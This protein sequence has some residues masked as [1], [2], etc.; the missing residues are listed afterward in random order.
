[1]TIKKTPRFI[2]PASCTACGDCAAV[3]PVIRPSEYDMELVGRKA[4]YKPYA[5]A[6]PGGFAIEKLD[7]APCRMACPANLN[8]QGYVQMV[9]MGKFREA[10]EIIM[11]D[12]PFPGTLGRV[13]PHACEKSCRRLEID[14]AISIRELKRVAADNTNLSDIPVPEIQRRDEKVAI[15]G[16]GP[17]GLTA[18]Y[19]L[20]LDGYQVSVY[21][22]MPEAGGMMRY[23]IPEHR[24]PRSVLDSEINNLKR[25]GIEIH[26][27]TV[28][29]KDLSIEELREHGAKA[30]F[31]GA[32]AWKGLKLRIQGEESKG[33][34]DVTSFLREV[35][36][37]NLKNLKGKA[38]II[39][40]GHSAL[41]GARVALRLGAEES[42][43][44]YRR[45]KTEM[46]AEP[47][48]IEEAEKEGIKIH[49]LVGPV[50]IVSQDGKVTGIECIRTRL[51][52]PDTTGRRKPIPI[53]G[54]EFIIEAD[55]IIP[56]IGQEP[57]LAFIGEKSD[58]EVSKW[59]LLVVNAETLQTNVPGIFAGGD[60]VTGPA[61]VIEAVDAG[62]RAAKYIAKYLQGEELPKEWHEEP[63]MGTNW[64]EI[65]DDEPVKHRM[66]APT[67]AVEKRFSG[68][69]EVNLTA[70][71]ET[72]KA[73]AARCL[74]CGGCCEC[75]ECV[76]ACKAHAVTF[77][78]HAQMA[79]T[80]TIDVGAVILAP[81]FKAFEPNDFATYQYGNF[82]NVVT[83]MEYE[84]ILS[85]TGPHQGHLLRPSD[86]KEPR[87]IGWLQCI[88][89]RDINQCDNGY[90]SSVCCMY[91]IKE[92]VIS[93]EHADYDLDTAIF[94]MD[95][96]TYGKDFEKYY[97]RAKEKAVRFV[98]ARLHTLEEDRE[99]KDIIVRYA[100]EK[101]DI[102]VETFD[103]MVL[104]VGM[105][106]RKE[107]T[108]MAKSLGIALDADNFADTGVFTPVETSRK[109]VY[110]CGAFQEPKDIPYSV[111][112]ASAAACGA[113]EL[114]SQARGTMV[115]EMVYPEEIDVSS[116]KPRIGVFVCNCGINI[117]GIV[118]VPAVVEYAGTLPGVV[119]IEDNLFTCSQDTQQKMVET[120]K[121]HKLNRIVV[122]ACTPRTHEPLFQETLKSAGLNK[123]LFEMANIRNQCSWVHSKEKEE[124]TAKAKDLV[125]MA[126]ARAN[127]IQPLPQPSI[128]VDSKAL[129]IGGGI[130]GM[131]AALGLAD[132]GYHT[133]LVEQSNVLGGNALNLFKTWRGD[134]IQQQI[135]QIIEKVSAHP[136]IDVYTE[137]AI[138]EATGFIGNYETTVTRNGNDIKLKHGAIVVAV[139]ADELKPQE[140]LY[141]EDNRVM[142]H[143]ELDE[144]MKKGEVS[145]IKTAVF[146]QC[147]GSREPQR[148][149]CS[150]VCC[151]HSVKS[152]LKLKEI[153]PETNVYILYRDIRTYGQ[154]E[155]LYKEARN[156][157]VIFI[158]YNLDG[159]PRVEKAGSGISV[160]IKDHIL[161]QDIVINPDLLVL[162]SGIIPRDN[163]AL[164]Q[165]FKLSLTEDGF[166]MEAHAKLRPVEFATD[167]IFL[168]G[169]A[170]YPKPIEES[171]AQ[172]KAAASRASVVLS[173]ETLTVEGVVSH[174]NEIMCRGCG[175]CVEACPFNAISLEPRPGGKIVAHVQEAMCKG[176]GS[177][178]VVC[179]TGAAAI[180]HYD[181]QEV[182]TMVEAAFK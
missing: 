11:R 126:V 105:E 131:T 90:C 7:K 16:S 172:A 8:V 141:G 160:T 73:E 94:F 75:Y 31:L 87:K 38:V 54:S 57:D 109:G 56:A 28:I 9:K 181:D 171:I 161:Q 58:L 83:S 113:K 182:L 108:E 140:Y 86:H 178:S 41:D 20:A 34:A 114:L 110:V 67:L 39:G 180:F 177:C 43:I 27:N 55:H 101:G 63:P 124:A 159:K 84:R 151:T 37:G 53:E 78:T 2:D 173:K 165:M 61:T 116:E 22:A 80:L 79:E 170:H 167:G 115:K 10:I 142:T 70:D 5:Q 149:Y 1:M 82:A 64:V 166:F 157:G 162:A 48:E 93:K 106:A 52:E 6:I 4:T 103:M 29:G 59:N 179:P 96:R 125:R 15:I 25:Y 111:M 168:A 17:A 107:V 88:G 18:A 137:A 51:T 169:M 163:N 97:D 71:E 158:R 132:Q 127:L 118:D 66:K 119:N 30:I 154:R 176:C 13:C 143:L 148:P 150:K 3:C 91:A 21:E 49:F 50:R 146:I 130:S 155:E 139:G 112:E 65:P 147:V 76:K 47:E 100:D 26:T 32:G 117:G 156:R 174:V 24:L 89:S 102:Q 44:I 136:M 69:V 95:M 40:G 12:L 74:N 77:E 128:S 134:D 98:R 92:A 68:F 81:G 129:V 120:I 46:L 72:A 14:E 60:V 85:A 121:E 42:H 45:S 164:A 135:N 33:V 19:F 123:Y 35:H 122:A 175:K 145:G 23:G 144:A 133:Y 99:T 104:S 152:A 138:K 36:L 62:K 153:N